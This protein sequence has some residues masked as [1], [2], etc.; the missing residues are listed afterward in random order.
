MSPAKDEE[1]SEEEEESDVEEE[2]YCA[3]CCEA[4]EGLWGGGEEDGDSAGGL[5]AGEPGEGEV[6]F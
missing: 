6:G 5:R 2:N 3:D 1:E 4:R